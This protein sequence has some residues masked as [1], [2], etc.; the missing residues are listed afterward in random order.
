MK[1]TLQRRCRMQGGILFSWQRWN[2]LIRWAGRES[3]R[4]AQEARR[5]ELLVLIHQHLQVNIW[6]LLAPYKLVQRGHC[7]FLQQPAF[8][9][10]WPSSH[11]GLCCLRVK[12]TM[13]SLTLHQKAKLTLPKRKTQF[14]MRS[15]F[16]RVFFSFD[17][18]E[19]NWFFIIPSVSSVKCLEKK[20]RKNTFTNG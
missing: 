19:L 11:K 16:K 13:S 12:Q 6:P 9:Q 10:L 7:N 1:K 20:H 5:R 17:G 8:C 15:H 18:I 2:R 3:D 14:V 4:R